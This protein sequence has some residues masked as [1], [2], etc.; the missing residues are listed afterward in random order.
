MR[1]RKRTASFIV[2]QQQLYQNQR[3]RRL[4]R[5]SN[6]RWTSHNRV[7]VVVYEKYAALLKAL[8]SIASANDFDGDTSST[9]KSL[10]LRIKC[11]ITTPVSNYLQSKSIDFIQAMKLV[12]IAKKTD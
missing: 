9:A 1:A 10:I 5:F 11:S 3:I 2:W 8:N 6:T 7:I 12:D 4:K